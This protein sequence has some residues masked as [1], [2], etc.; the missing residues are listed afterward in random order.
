MK[1]N[2]KTVCLLLIVLFPLVMGTSCSTKNQLNIPLSKDGEEKISSF[3][4][5][6][7]Y[8]RAE[9]QGYKKLSQF[10]T[11]SDGT[12]LAVDIF[13]PD[14]GPAQKSFPVVLEYSPYGRSFTYPDMPWYSQLASKFSSGNPGPV[15][16]KAMNKHVRRLLAHGYAFAAADMRGTGASYGTQI[17][18]MPRLGKDG[19]DLIDWIASQEWSNG[20]VG[21]QGQSF[22]GWSQLATARYKP[23]ALKCIMPAMIMFEAYTANNP[24]GIEAARWLNWYSYLLNNHHHNR[25]SLDDKIWK[26]LPTT[27]VIDEDGDGEIADE[28]P[29]MIQGDPTILTDDPLPV[30]KDGIERNEQYYYQATMEHKTNMTVLEMKERYSTI[31]KVI[32]T[33]DGLLLAYDGSPGYFIPTIAES[34]IAV[35]HIG[36]WMDGFTKGTTKLYSTMRVSNPSK[37]RIGPRFHL[38]MSVTKAYADYLGYTDDL[39]EQSSFEALRFFDHY[40][41]GINNNIDREPAV[42]I[43]VMHKGW[44]S[45]DMWPPR[46]QVMTPLFMAEGGKL[47]I[48][49]PNETGMDSYQVDFSHQSNY[50]S[51][52][53]N[54]WLMLKKTDDVMWRTEPD[55][56]SMLYQ[57]EPLSDEMEI[58]GHP[59]IELWISSNQDDGDV[60]IYLTDVDENNRSVYVTEGQLRAGW[61][62][63]RNDDD[64][65][66]NVVDV[67]PD[68]PWHGYKSDQ[69]ADRVFNDNKIV[70]L[71]FDLL[72]I[73]WNFKKGHSIRVAIAG[74][75]EGNF[76]L[77][78]KL[79]ENNDVQKCID[80]QINIHRDSTMLSRIELPVIPE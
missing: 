76:R 34:G 55:K 66:L 38:P 75:D 42:Q 53:T 70:K 21:M 78:P 20:K 3:G 26:T 39:V 69:Y 28:I 46:E 74:A 40:L 43:Y 73:A 80:T 5:Y 25:F 65:V 59:V 56:K 68:L 79:C 51:E 35:Y 9:Y 12:R 54:R 15:Y 14:K 22:V 6:T 61:H 60:F 57:T 19:K 44:R 27:P 17:P 50:G 4:K 71:S 37:L 49:S 2:L 11:V 77:N 24:G 10:M 48:N 7:G 67:K 16:D 62:Q 29:L 18:L 63:L 23:E 64:Q 41:K 58:A 72:P 32:D 33:N 31:D 8:S 52:Q 36:G 47:L 30:Y 1:T 45:F 13:L